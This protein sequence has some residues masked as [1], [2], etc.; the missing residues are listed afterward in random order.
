MKTFFNWKMIT[1]GIVFGGLFCMGLIISPALVWSEASAEETLKWCE[2]L[3]FTASRE[4]LEAK[5]TGDYLQAQGALS[6]ADEAGYLVAA[7]SKTAQETGN[8]KLAWSAYNAS[9]AVG[10]AIEQVSKTA[11]YIASHDFNPEIIRAAKDLLELCNAK[12]E[13]NRTHMEIAL[14]PLLGIYES[15]EAYSR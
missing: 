10:A 7:I 12:K 3:A 6:L 4:A 1:S 15:A 14:R 9:N 5:A 11:R 2:E 13:E 8:R